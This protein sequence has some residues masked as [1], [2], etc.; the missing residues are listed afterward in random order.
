MRN[1]H[2]IEKSAVRHGEYVGWDKDGNRY[3]IRKDGPNRDRGSWWV[4]PRAP[5]FPYGPVAG[6]TTHMPVFYAGTLALVSL[7]LE[8]KTAICAMPRLSHEVQS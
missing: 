2:N 3:A 6:T 5:M 8:R 7:R 4:Y 1:Y